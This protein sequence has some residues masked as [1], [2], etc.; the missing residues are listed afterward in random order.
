MPVP[1]YWLLADNSID[2]GSNMARTGTF[3]AYLKHAL[4]FH[5]RLLLSDSLVV[6]TPN[7]R[8]A[9]QADPGLREYLVSGAL[10]IARRMHERDDRLLELIE[11][12]D[13]LRPRGMNPGFESDHMPFVEDSDLLQLQRVARS[14]PY[15]LPTVSGYYTDSVKRLL[16]DDRFLDLLGSDSGIVVGEIRRRIEERQYLDQTFFERPGPG[17]LEEAVGKEVWARRAGIIQSFEASY[18][19]NAIPALL[20]ADVIFSH[21]HAT[22]RRIVRRIG[23][24]G[25]GAT[26]H[27][28]LSRGSKTLYER[29][30]SAL[31]TSG[32]A[33]LR[34]SD[35]FVEFQRKLRSL[36]L[37][38]SI[39]DPGLDVT[40]RETC[41]ALYAYHE[42][43]DEALRFRRAVDRGTRLLDGWHLR[44]FLK[45]GAWLLRLGT[46]LLSKK[47]VRATVVT[48]L[49]SIVCPGYSDIFLKY[50]ALGGVPGIEKRLDALPSR[51]EGAERRQRNISESLDP[52]E[53]SVEI[54]PKIFADS[55]YGGE[56]NRLPC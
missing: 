38:D 52:V 36:R 10:V 6:N 27:V 33:R 9:L 4:L 23:P 2:L 32:L 11:I 35:E 28:D 25:A 14:L 3:V 17:S 18:Y 48:G 53:A 43:I 44:G 30:L 26:V 7:L 56:H 1:S 45:N 21:E 54:A 20:D 15:E 42:R 39:E 8:V 13:R 22:H 46:D 34:A 31:S 29:A 40:V 55:I 47:P 19:R 16:T 37:I 49:A 5:Q 24:E 12:R 50:Y 51:L 41:A